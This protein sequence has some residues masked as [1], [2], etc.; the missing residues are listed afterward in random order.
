MKGL[1]R[2]L[3]VT[4]CGRSGTKYTAELLQKLGMDVRHEEMGAD[5]IATW[6]MAVDS[7]DS[8]WGGG[9]R[10]IRFGAILHQVRHPLR[11]I[12][13]LTTFTAPSWNYIAKYIPCPAEEPIVLRAAK[14]WYYW[15][16]E[17]EKVAT[18]RYRIEA[19]ENVFPEFC[20]RAG[21]KPSLE[22]LHNTS[23]L[24]NSR[25]VR[26]LMKWARW[27]LNYAHL[28]QSTRKLDFM[29]K[30]ESSYFGEPFTWAV[31]EKWAPGW[32]K[33]IQA[34]SIRYGY[35]ALDDMAAAG[36]PSEG[37]KDIEDAT[38]LPA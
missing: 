19:I 34:M 12:P 18:W 16:E 21:V 14:Y 6:C 7:E 26:P 36:L 25:K 30:R 37:I 22:A 13:S 20:A 27:I 29:Y 9:R 38:F 5:G 4:G 10:G 2:K 32:S 23:T 3:L 33:K 28:G 15:N 8:P 31:L 17:A 11:V 24:V 1:D 35:N